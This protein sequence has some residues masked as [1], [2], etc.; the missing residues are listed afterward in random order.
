M[1]VESSHFDGLA[2]LMRLLA[3][4]N[5]GTAVAIQVADRE[6]GRCGGAFD[7]L[8]TPAGFAACEG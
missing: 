5:L 6:S 4:D 7:E 1:A 2:F 3:D 8:M